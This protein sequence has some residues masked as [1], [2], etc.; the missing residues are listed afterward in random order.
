MDRLIHKYRSNDHGSSPGE[1][2]AGQESTIEARQPA[3]TPQLRYAIPDQPQRS[4]LSMK[5]NKSEIKDRVIGWFVLPSSEGDHKTALEGLFVPCLLYGKTHWRLKNVVLVEIRIIS[6][7][8]MVATRC[9]GSMLVLLLYN[10]PDSR[11]GL[12]GMM[13]SSHVLWSMCYDAT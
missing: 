2:E 8:L 7:L 1:T 9:V 4:E 11:P 12:W 10:V 13:L 5:R 3:V 6:S